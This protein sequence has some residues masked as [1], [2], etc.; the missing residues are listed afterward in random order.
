MKCEFALFALAAAAFA[1]SPT[2]KDALDS[3]HGLKSVTEAGIN[4]IEYSS[5]VLDTKVKIDRYLAEAPKDDKQRTAIDNA[6]NLYVIARGAWSASI[7]EDP[8]LLQTIGEMA[9]RPTVS[10]ACPFDK[11]ML[12]AAGRKGLDKSKF[13]TMLRE[14][15]NLTGDKKAVS[16]GFLLQTTIGA[17]PAPLWACA[18]AQIAD[19]DKIASTPK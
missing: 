15:K 16:V 19:A 4:F 17:E 6:M 2:A 10:T 12:E 5:R 3:L 18:N 9:L 14:V 13:E 1:Q 11:I 8:A 7:R